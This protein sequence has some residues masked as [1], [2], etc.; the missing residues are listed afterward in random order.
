MADKFLSQEEIDLL[1]QSLGKEGAEEQAGIDTSN[2]RTFDIT[3]LEHVSMSRVA[4]L[5]L[6]IEKWVRNVK[7][8]LA[9]IVVNLTDV[10][11]EEI[12]L[13]KFSDFLLKIPLPSAIA[14]L[15]INPLK[16]SS[17]LVIDPKLIFVIVSSIFGGAPK[18]YKVEGK[19]FTKVEMRIIKRVVEVLVNSFEEAWNVVIEGNIE[20]MGIEVNPKF[21]T[22]ASPR[23]RFIISRITIDIEGF[24][25][26]VYMAISDRSIEPFKEKLRNV[27]DIDI[28]TGKEVL[29]ENI[30][31]VPVNLEASLGETTITVGDLINLEEGQILRLN[32]HIKEP[33]VVKIQGEP[34]LKAILGESGTMKAIKILDYLE[35]E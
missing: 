7:T 5:E 14:I 27:S 3:S 25:G 24:E 34:K 23:E 1:L 26:F 10:R 28:M 19:E 35:E 2:V 16:G 8:S 30:K 6:I 20:I 13:M 21:L 29:V 12:T 17:F 9:S 33:I 32:R 11:S 18:P 4:G 15:N 31:H 22:V